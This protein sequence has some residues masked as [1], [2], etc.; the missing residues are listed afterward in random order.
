[1]RTTRHLKRDSPSLSSQRRPA[2][3]PHPLLALQQSAGNQAVVRHLA[4]FA[5]PEEERV[6]EVMEKLAHGRQ[7]LYAAMKRAPD[8]EERRKHRVALRAFDAPW[9]KR[10]RAL[11]TSKQHPDPTVQ[12]MVL[13]ALQLEAIA[14]AEGALM[15][16]KDAETV[17][18]AEFNPYSKRDWCGMF[19]AE[20]FLRSNLDE[21]L[22]MDY[23]HVDNVVDYF[24]Y[25]YGWGEDAR[26]KKWIHA[27]D[28]WHELRDYHEARG[29]VRQWLTAD[30]IQRGGELDVRAG[31][32]AVIDHG[33]PGDANHIVMVH[34]YD[35]QSRRLNTIAGNDG[36]FEVENPEQPHKGPRDDDHQALE[37]AAGTPLSEAWSGHRVGMHT[38]DLGAQPTESRMR[39]LR[40]RGR[41]PVR[42]FAVGRP[43][44]VDF[45]DHRYDSTSR[46]FPP[47]TR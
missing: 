41:R 34:S 47:A 16:A 30:E 23:L 8:E 7:T 24:T 20:K 31:D 33:V 22:K 42:V 40:R 13:A 29:S 18:R 36:G 15:D 3:P 37:A 32:I 11:G 17:A 1:M 26:I 9:L 44:I 28:A 25:R 4:R 27:E 46:K 14:N 39:E 6:E 5:S 12:D 38:H 43:S 10:L 35:P 21:D 19:A 2:A 45:E